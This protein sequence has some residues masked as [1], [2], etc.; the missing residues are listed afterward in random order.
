MD[1]NSIQKTVLGVI[2]LGVA[3]SSPMGSAIVTRNILK[4][5]NTPPDDEQLLSEKKVRDSLYNLR[6]HG[7]VK[8]VGSGAE[9][10][11]DLTK[12]G[13]GALRGYEVGS[14]VLSRRGTWDKKWR[15]VM[16]D[17]P[18]DE[19]YARDVLRDKLKRMG[20][21]QIQQSVWAYPYPCGKEVDVLC[22]Y[23]G[24]QRYVLKFTGPLENDSKLRTLLNKKGFDLQ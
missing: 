14:L 18:E 9:R 7:Y 2:A 24:V 1:R 17:I 16:F 13:R 12:K 21:F 15:L 20:F 6:K 5:I 8:V 19:R 10:R 22:E 23:F 3:C 11:L 4:K